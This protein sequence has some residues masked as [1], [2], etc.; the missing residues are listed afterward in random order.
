[1]TD[2]AMNFVTLLSLQP[3]RHASALS[4]WNEHIPFAGWIVEA[5]R[6]RVLVEL[7]THMGTS[8]FSFCDAVAR[9]GLSTRCFAVDTW[10][11]DEH[12]GRYGE[13][14]YGAATA[15]NTRL[16]GGF[17]R[18]IRSTFDDAL[19]EFRAS[20]IDLL[21]IDGLHTYEAVRHDVDSW[22]PKLSDR[23]VL[24][25]HDTNERR[26]GFGV[27]RVFA[28]LKAVYPTFEF[29]HGHGLGIVCVGS[30]V[31]APVARLAGLEATDPPAAGLV[32][33]TYAYLGRGISAELEVSRVNVGLSD[34]AARARRVEPDASSQSEAAEAVRGEGAVLRETVG[35]LG[36]KLSAA[37]RRIKR[38]RRRS[39]VTQRRLSAA[40]GSLAQL[41]RRK[42]VRVA[43][44]LSRPLRALR[45]RK[46]SS[47]RSRR[48]PGGDTGS[49]PGNRSQPTPDQTPPTAPPMQLLPALG[50]GGG[51][52]TVIVAVFN[53]PDDLEAC[54]A[55]LVRNTSGDVRL[56]VVDDA[57]TDSRVAK[58]LERYESFDGITVLHNPENLG[59]VRTVNRGF[60]TASGDVVILNSDAEVTPG[61]L[62]RLRLAVR[63]HPDAGTVTAL[64]DNAGAFSAPEAGKRND[65]PPYLTR[66]QVGRLVAQW[67]RRVHPEGPTGNGFC[68][69]IR[70][71]CL[72]DVGFFDEEAFPGAYGAENDFG[73][74]I[75]AEG[76]TN[77]VEDAT[78]VFHGGY[79]S[80]GSEREDLKAA[81]H[82]VLKVRHPDY[83]ALAGEF[84]RSPRFVTARR[85]IGEAFS[86]AS[87]RG[88][89]PRP[90]VLFVLHSIGGGTAAATEDLISGLEPHYESYLL[91]SDAEVVTLHR[92][93]GWASGSRQDSMVV[94]GEWRLDVPISLTDETHA[95]YGRIV[96]SVL[97]EHSIEVVHIQHLIGH[98]MELPEVARDLGIPVVL[99]FHDFYF[100]CPTAH[101]IDDGGRFCGGACS[102][103]QG[104]CRGGKPR[105]DTAPHLK[106]SWV[107]TWRERVSQMF[108]E[109]EAFVTTSES[110]RDLHL[111][112]FPDLEGR[113]FEII[114]HG[115]NLPT[116]APPVGVVPVAGEPIRVLLPGALVLHKGSK[117]VRRLVELD[118]DR[119]IEFHSMGLTD[120]N[121]PEAVVAHGAYKRSEFESEARRIGP[122]FVG[123]FSITAESFSY[124][125]TE[126][127]AAGIPVLASR[128]GAL[129]ERVTRHGGG[130]LVD[131][132]SPEEVY[133]RILEIAADAD[134]YRRERERTAAAALASPTVEEM[135]FEYTALYGD[136]LRARRSFVPVSGARARQC[137]R[138]GVFLPGDGESPSSHVRVVRRLMDPGLVGEVAWHRTTAERFLA[139]RSDRSGFD[140]ALVQRNAIP[141]DLVSRFLDRC[142]VEEVRVVFELDDDLLSDDPGWRELGAYRPFQESIRFLLSAA[143]VVSV[144]TPE[145]ARRVGHLARHV[146]VLENGLDRSLWFRPPGD[147]P[148]GSRTGGAVRLF[149]VGGAA[150][151]AD[152]AILREALGLASEELGKTVELH[153]AGGVPIDEREAWFEPIEIPPGEVSYPRFVGWLRS[154]RGDFD[155]A[156]APLEDT[157]LNRSKSDL[158]FLEYAALGLPGIYSSGPAFS[159]VEDGATGLVVDNNPQAW[160]NAIVRIHTDRHLRESLVEAG[161]ERLTQRRLLDQQRDEF[162]SMLAPDGR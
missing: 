107:Y 129:G 40:Q 82:E 43:M 73:I 14:L 66:D 31:P 161:L 51:P 133:R 92:F 130:W 121:V 102:S 11:G 101:L 44:A 128:L 155:M 143:D 58:V 81:G 18:L 38:L 96:Q 146:V 50:P 124:V 32:A 93:K 3:P 56:L 64:S 12:S 126:A 55:A 9:L 145:L 147:L 103:G 6:P 23:G 159:T 127:W 109:V 118:R 57:S 30:E 148:P 142:A 8:Y 69:Y 53:A 139:A 68:M 160:A 54:L 153:V 13:E 33:A 77:L 134:G 111:R 4:A 49:P 78:Y 5:T 106:H 132:D 46:R 119:Q 104:D 76:W 2:P 122:S 89:R 123:I 24:L 63:L 28:E 80:F 45:R 100:V 95:E 84:I 83:P 70:R 152:I 97:I 98:T 37:R 110:I 74:R 140:V 15:T 29:V 149:F 87:R 90:R 72:D 85:R 79:K 99:S 67:A 16:F 94:V 34:E 36:K 86:T 136:L 39:R 19:A 108:G 157:A 52:V 151:G 131:P 113:P 47:N 144:S 158:R 21:H 17:S 35:D 10:R 62:D 71:Q 42:S 22:L 61:W 112:A 115:R 138:V 116:S 59:Y 7:G 1:M 150:H 114:E 25:L 141:P 60:A 105:L 156:V 41:R 120:E 135:A 48:G 162:L 88:I 137:L 27:H 65:P 91:V 20:S 26:E 154:L 75:R 125:L 117:L